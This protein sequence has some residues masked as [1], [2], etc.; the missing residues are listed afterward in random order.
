M[1][2]ILKVEI[3]IHLF[4]FLTIF[5]RKY[6]LRFHYLYTPKEGHSPFWINRFIHLFQQ[7][8][9]GHPLALPLVNQQEMILH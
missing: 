7:S 1:L 4:H 9:L 2:I 3:N 8:L 6:A 5:S